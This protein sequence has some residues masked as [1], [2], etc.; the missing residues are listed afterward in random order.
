MTNNKREYP[1]CLQPNDSSVQWSFTQSEFVKLLPFLIDRES[2]MCKRSKIVS[3]GFGLYS[4][5]QTVAQISAQVGCSAPYVINVIDTAIRQFSEHKFY[6]EFLTRP[7][8]KRSLSNLG[9]IIDADITVTRQAF[10]EVVLNSI[11]DADFTKHQEDNITAAQC[12]L[13]ISMVYGLDGFPSL[14]VW[15]IDFCLRSEAEKIDWCGS[16]DN[17]ANRILF[18]AHE[19]LSLHR[20]K[21]S[22]ARLLTNYSHFLKCVF[23]RDFESIVDHV[24]TEKQCLAILPKLVSRANAIDGN[25]MTPGTCELY[26]RAI[27]QYFEFVEAEYRFA[28]EPI[29]VSELL[30]FCRK[31]SNCAVRHLLVPMSKSTNKLLPMSDAPRDG[32]F[33]DVY[34]GA[35]RY[36]NCQCRS[37]EQGWV[38]VNIWDGISRA[39]L[40]LDTTADG[41]MPVYMPSLEDLEQSGSN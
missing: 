40:D 5:R 18:V 2:E 32:T 24:I 16:D 21:F 22:K 4:K 33:I 38:Y 41:W 19:H 31:F 12:I 1:F 10:V 15:Q 35:K 6:C 8:P 11:F 36:P 30:A 17:L 20:D 34:I 14:H 23:D 27:A 28:N 3:L 26:A 39:F 25:L 9:D 29:F 13:A 7:L 37:Y